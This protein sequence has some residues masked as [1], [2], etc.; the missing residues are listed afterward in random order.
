MELKISLREVIQ[1]GVSL[2]RLNAIDCTDR[3]DRSLWYRDLDCLEWEHLNDLASLI[4]NYLFQLIRRPF[5][6]SN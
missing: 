4:P 5:V 2:N 6:K 1:F 3:L